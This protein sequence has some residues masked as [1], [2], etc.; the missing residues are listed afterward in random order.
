MPEANVVLCNCELLEVCEI[1]LTWL[2]KVQ[3]NIPVVK[4]MI[5][6]NTVTTL[7]ILDNLILT[8][9]VIF[10]FNFDLITLLLYRIIATTTTSVPYTKTYVYEKNL[11]PYNKSAIFKVV[12]YVDFIRYIL[13]YCTVDIFD[14]VLNE[15]YIITL[16]CNQ[17][18][19]LIDYPFTI[20]LSEPEVDL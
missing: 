14:D 1:C 12:E 6:F 19:D 15:L 7:G 18:Y 8:N 5:Y 9:N 11:M 2:Y 16:R 17:L 13:Q 10:K 20:Q 3:K 4:T